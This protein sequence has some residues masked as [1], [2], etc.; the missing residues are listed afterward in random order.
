MRK[1]AAGTKVS[2]SQG[3]DPST[4]YVMRH[5]GSSTDCLLG[6]VGSAAKL[7]IEERDRGASLRLGRWRPFMKKEG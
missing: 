4:R 6:T 3:V 7:T 5:V 2:V 1:F